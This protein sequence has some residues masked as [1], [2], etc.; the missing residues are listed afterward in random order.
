[1][2]ILLIE[3]DLDTAEFVT[4]GLREQGYAVQHESDSPSGVL[5]SASGDFDVIVFDRLLPGMDGID[6]VR[7]LRGSKLDTPIL[8]LTALSGIDDRVAGLEAGAD[9]YMV[10]PFAF[11]ELLARVR[12]LARRK[13]L[14]KD[15][16]ELQ[17]GDLALNRASRTV[18]RAGQTIELLPREFQILEL[19]LMH[20]G[21]VITRTMLL[22]RVWGYTFDPKTSLVQTHVSRLRTKIDKPF[23]TELIKTVRGSGYM[24]KAD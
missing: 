22:D 14:L 6:A 15:E 23:T 24:L 5:A 9:D 2:N 12:A 10:K 11:S 18:Q 16:I 19:F 17:A 4:R 3:D 7:I 13:P 8:M 20:P 21:Q 1:M